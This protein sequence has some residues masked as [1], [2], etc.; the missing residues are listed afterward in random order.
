M[1]RTEH[2]CRGGAI[3]QQLLHKKCSDLISIRLVFKLHFSGKGIGIE[4]FE[5]LFTVGANHFRLWEMNMGVDQARQNQLI[6]IM[7][8]L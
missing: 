7:L 6:R 5:Q 1:Y 3:F 2:Q 4:P 8:D